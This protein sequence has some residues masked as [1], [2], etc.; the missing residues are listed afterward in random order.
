MTDPLPFLYESTGVE[1]YF[2][3]SRDPDTRSRRVFAF[4]RPETLADWAAESETLRRRLAQ[5]PSDHPLA[6]NG[7]RDCQIEAITGLEKSF[8]E[9]RPRALIHMAIRIYTT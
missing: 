6:T 3:D 9:N 2:R 1:T 4:H 7:M 8:A 5:M